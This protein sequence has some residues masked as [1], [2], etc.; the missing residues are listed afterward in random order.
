MHSTDSNKFSLSP[1]RTSSAARPGGSPLGGRVTLAAVIVVLIMAA[2]R[3]MPEK[4]AAPPAAPPVPTPQQPATPA[5]PPPA[6]TPAPSPAAAGHL[7]RGNWTELPGWRDDDP[8]AV[9]DALLASC[10]PLKTQ[11]AWRTVCTAALTAPRPDRERARRFFELNFIPYQLLQPDGGS[12]GLATGYYEPLLRGSRKPTARYRYP[13]YGTPDDLISIDLPAFGIESRES[14]L[15]GRL[16]GKRVVPYFDRAQIES[17]AA[18]LRGRE[19]AW[20]DDPV[21]LFFLQI[22]GS[23]RLDLDGGG[24]MRVGFA[25]HNGQPYRSIGRL[26]IDRGELPAERTS[27]QGIKAWAQQNP[28]KL[29]EVLDYN[30]RYIFFRELPAGLSGPLGAL[31]VPLTARRSIAVDPRFVPLGAPVFLA[32][33]WPLS[34]K[35]LNQLMLAQDTGSAIRGAVRADFFWGYGDDAGREAGRMKQALRLWV[36]LPQGY[37]VGNAAD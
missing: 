10:G 25:E 5:E 9:W 16:D 31:G 28:D 26:L 19:I 33:T 36:L 7:R 12:E 21:E 20:V 22:Q 37:P 4:P 8:A 34:N 29:R 24:V 23:G 3:S 2:C 6:V 15:R 30:P 35:P 14:R 27:M 18:P 13:I 11:E 32:T 17:A 1:K